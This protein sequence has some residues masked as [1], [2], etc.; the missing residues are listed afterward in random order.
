MVDHPIRSRTITVDLIDHN[1]G[2]QPQSQRLLGYEAR[3]RHGPFD[4]IDKQQDTINHAKHALHFTAKVRVTRCIH[5]VDVHALVIN[6]QILGQNRDTPFLFEI[7]RVHDAFD[8]V[9][10]RRKTPCLLQQLV[11]QCRLTVVD[12]SNNRDVTNGTGHIGVTL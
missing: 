6:G 1:D 7:V 2:L 12:V 8:N 11:D 10:V 9:L 3:L 4:G 5:D